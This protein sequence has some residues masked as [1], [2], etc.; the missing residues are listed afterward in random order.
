MPHLLD[1][2]GGKVLWSSTNGSR[3]FLVVEYFGKAKVSE[4]NVPKPVNDDVFRLQTK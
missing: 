1:D 4:F 2:F 3:R